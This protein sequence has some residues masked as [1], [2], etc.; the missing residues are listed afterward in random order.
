MFLKALC[1]SRIHYT[2]KSVTSFMLGRVK[3]GILGSDFDSEMRFNML[4]ML[5]DKHHGTQC[6]GELICHNKKQQ[7]VF[8]VYSSVCY[9][10]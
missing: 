9:I 7:A 6:C 1:D 3:A 10:W 4:N 8:L 5:F 2:E